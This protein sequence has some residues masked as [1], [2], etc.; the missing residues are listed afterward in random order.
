ML[1]AAVGSFY[2]RVQKLRYL[3]FSGVWAKILTTALLGPY[4]CS[5]PWHSQTA[6]DLLLYTIH[7]F[8]LFTKIQ[9]VQTDQSYC[10]IFFSRHVDHKGH[11]IDRP[12][13]SVLSNGGAE[14]AH[15]DCCWK[16]CKIYNHFI[17]HQ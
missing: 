12:F 9:L 3:D 4:C 15:E 2:P 10:L 6:V 13:G 7:A 16:K 8:D 11:C 14:N 17:M 5:Q 1:R